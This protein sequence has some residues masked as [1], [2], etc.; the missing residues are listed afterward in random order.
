MISGAKFPGRAQ[1]GDALLSN[2]FVFE[3]FVIKS[4]VFNSSVF[5]SSVGPFI[6]RVRHENLALSRILAHRSRVPNETNF[7][8]F[9]EP[10]VGE[11]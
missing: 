4:S 7:G 3:R 9:R 11:E 6:H 5:K 2:V 8:L 1:L 10:V